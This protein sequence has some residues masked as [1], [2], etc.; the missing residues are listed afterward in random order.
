M[1]LCKGNQSLEDECDGQPS[2]GDNS[3]LRVS[4]EADPLRTAREVAKQFNTDYSTVIQHLEQ[5]E[6]VKKLTQ[7]VP[8]ELTENQKNLCFELSSLILCN[9]NK[10]PFLNQ[11][12]MCDGKWILYISQ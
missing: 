3:Q 9:N 1:K 11:I 2:E 12:V 5:T 7:W 4:I 6:K 8:H 10:K